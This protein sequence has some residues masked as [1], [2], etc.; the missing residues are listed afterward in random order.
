MKLL[1]LIF[2]GIYTSAYAGNL[3]QPP[4]LKKEPVEEQHYLK[5]IYNNWNNLEGTTTNPD[6]S[7]RG[8]YGDMLLLN[9]SGTYYLE[10]CVS[11]PNG[12]VWVG[13]QLTDT[14]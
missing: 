13:E 5:E 7:R 8:N 10:I 6:G 4:V 11:S 9:S 1:L 3:T 14:P 12:T 2:L